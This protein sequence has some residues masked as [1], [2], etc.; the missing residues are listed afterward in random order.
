MKISL[1]VQV[2]L[3]LIAWLFASCS[4]WAVEDQNRFI[5]LPDDNNTETYDLNTVQMIA[6]SRFTI[7]KTTIDNPDVMK[8]ELTALG[9]LQSYC[10]HPDGAYPAPAELLTLGPPDMP[11]RNI[12]VESAKKNK[13]RSVNWFYPY[14]RLALQTTA[15]IEERF[16]IPVPCVSSKLSKSD[17]QRWILE[18]RAVITNGTQAKYQFDCK[19]GMMSIPI[20][21][22]D[23]PAKAQ[24][25]FAQ[26]GW[27]R[28]YV[29]VCNKVTNEFPFLPETP[30]APNVHPQ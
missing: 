10:T 6:P 14:K 3:I 20:F 30:Q 2:P 25:V 4:S 24:M 26:G 27:L 9:T 28:D 17:V 22:E 15:G 1:S 16:T 5:E 18:T 29:L 12:E 11:V 7:I 21:G 19:R 13:V 23:D 8:L